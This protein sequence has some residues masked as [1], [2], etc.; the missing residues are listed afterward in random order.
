MDVKSRRVM[1]EIWASSPD[2]S[3]FSLDASSGRTAATVMRLQREGYLSRVEESTDERGRRVIAGLIAPEGE[4]F[5]RERF[6]AGERRI[7]RVP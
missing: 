1:N 6:S 4:S 3:A 2:G 5:C 7:G